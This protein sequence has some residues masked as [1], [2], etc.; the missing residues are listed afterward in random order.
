[1]P[2]RAG[3]VS[4]SDEIK[5]GFV[6]RAERASEAVKLIRGLHPYEEPLIMVIPLCND[7]VEG[8]TKDVG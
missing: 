7:E 5:M 1:V 6:C 4:S 2:G 3:E 8:S